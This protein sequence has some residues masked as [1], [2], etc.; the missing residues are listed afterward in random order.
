MGLA[1]FLRQVGVFHGRQTV[2]PAAVREP[3]IPQSL[4]TGRRLQVVEY[5][6]LANGQYTED[7]GTLKQMADTYG[8]TYR[9]VP[10]PPNFKKGP[11][12]ARKRRP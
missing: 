3:E 4:L 2:T 12:K 5:F 10:A 8:G 7:N 9:F 6:V 1:H 11:G